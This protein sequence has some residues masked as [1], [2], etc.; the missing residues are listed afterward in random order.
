ME[1]P[2]SQIKQTTLVE[3]ILARIKSMLLN[4]Q[5]KPGQ[6]LPSEQEL[7]EQFGVGK[8]SVREA[9]KM[10]NA[11]GV[12][13][14]RQGY[15]T[16][17]CEAPKEDSL[18][19]LIFQMIL[20]QGSDAQLLEFRKLFESAYTF[21]AMDTMTEE[22][23]EELKQKIIPSREASKDAEFHRTILY[24]THNPYIKRIGD[25]LIDLYEVTLERDVEARRIE[26]HVNHDHE[27]IYEALV[28]KDRRMLKNVLDKS[29]EEYGKLFLNGQA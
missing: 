29:Y 14:S 24:G 27:L 17:V 18:N 16:M 21:M 19:P 8:S 26:A 10:L 13:E 9:V 22:D 6:R 5:L 23:L 20:L 15:G 2:I 25:I 3:K 12:V 28:R 11:V 7:A 1:H 4:G